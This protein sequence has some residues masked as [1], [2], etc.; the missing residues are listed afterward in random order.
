[1]SGIVYVDGV[2]LEEDYIS[3][4]TTTKLD[5]IGPKTVP[6]TLAEARSA[7][8]KIHFQIQGN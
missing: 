1:M 6:E 7:A 4:L 8:M 2:A 5:F 3:E